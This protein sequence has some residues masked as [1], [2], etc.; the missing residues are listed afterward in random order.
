MASILQDFPFPFFS[1]Q[2]TLPRQTQGWCHGVS[3]FS[4]FSSCVRGM[5]SMVSFLYHLFVLVWRL[6]LA[7]PVV[8]EA[9]V[10]EQLLAD[11]NKLMTDARFKGRLLRRWLDTRIMLGRSPSVQMGK[12][13]FL[14]VWTTW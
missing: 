5:I 1:M 12:L 10:N 6:R 2:M 14:E 4:F 3:S 11:A 8:E 13:S 7:E 9:K